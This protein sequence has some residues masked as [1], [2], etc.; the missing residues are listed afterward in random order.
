VSWKEPYRRL[1]ALLFRSR[2]ERDLDDETRLHLEM[3][4]RKLESRGL[5]PAE[6]RRQALIAFGG[7]EGVKEDCRDRRG[8]RWLEDVGRDLV[9]GLRLFRK[10][11]GYATAVIAALT[12]GI[13]GNTALFTLFAAVAL[14]PLPV[15]RPAELVSL[16][17]V[18]PEQPRSIFSF[19]D[20][21]YY[22]DHTSVFANLAAESA[23]GLR[24]SDSSTDASG[25]A[26]DAEPVAA[27]FVTSNYLRTFGVGTIAGRDF[28]PEDERLTAGPYPVLLSENYW[29]RRFG[30]DVSV[31]GRTLTFS[32]MSATVI[33][34]TPRDFMGARPDVPDIWI[35]MSARFDSQQRALDRTLLCCALTGRL[36]SGAT[37]GQAQVEMSLLATSLRREYPIAERRWDVLTA[38]AAPFGANH[39][40]IVKM[41]VVLQ[42]AMGLVLLIACTNVAGLLLGKTAA[43]RR[44]IAIRLSL[45]ATR[46]RLVRQLVTEAVL[47]SMVVGFASFFLTWQALVVAGHRF[48]EA[49][50][51]Q[52]ATVAIDLTPD[53][54]V[55]FY[56]LLV[57]VVAG[58]SFA[59]APAL[60]SSRPDLVSAL[61]DERAGAGLLR[62]S[63]LQAGLVTAQIAVSLALLIGAGL[64]TSSS[65]RLLAVDP[66]FQTRTV[67]NLTFSSPPR[68]GDS[69]ALAFELQ[70]RLEERLRA[71]PTVT[72]VSSASR[73]PL[74]GNVSSTHI[75]AAPTD[76]SAPSG[77]PFPYSYVSPDYFQTLGMRFL[78][79]RTFTSAEV[80][81]GAAVAVVSGALAHRLWPNGDALGQRISL[82]SPTEVHDGG[83]RAPLSASTE[84]VG[85]VSDIYSTDLTAPDPGAVYL[86]QPSGDRNR[87][88]LVRVAGDA[89]SVAA[90][91]VRDVRAAEPGLTVSAETLYDTMASSGLAVVFRVSAWVFA[92]VG[93]VGLALAFVG[94][95]ALVAYS[96][97]QQTRE[98]GIRMALGAER[99]DVI[100]LL[101]GEKAKSIAAGIVLGAGLGVLL[102]AVLS[103]RVFL[104]GARLL[105]P[106]VI[107]A[108]SLLTGGCALLAAYFPVRRAATL[109][110]SRTLRFD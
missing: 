61:K 54:Q 37:L 102:S 20:F 29:E 93:L 63:R 25:S 94:V 50:A 18:T 5:G 27:L 59:L 31:L 110:P 60:Q 91:L 103:S 12:I 83:R 51:A 90:G 99:R 19:A 2:A 46:R 42:I 95:Y 107:V 9:F 32:S 49:W 62:K 82:G 74:G 1:R 86:P 65:A 16:W 14:K 52:G 28:L 43:R 85:V 57:S 39:G 105:D 77:Q 26:G 84:V 79:G 75:A 23:A 6:A 33:G 40:N 64:L 47:I 92:A 17:R 106:G 58:V 38:S 80:D 22:R 13:G 21:V 70:T 3:E 78:R 34:I 53:L 68:P 8:T 88:L 7:A 15:P 44:E 55:F 11:R 72:S 67:L 48:S 81:H 96:V 109:E 66:G 104:Q 71:I 101:I 4:T 108:V 100:R 30:R 69:R 45:G 56:A 36:K 24:V 73:A 76:P 41:F 89:N 87:L 97:S 98:V 35:T 10:D